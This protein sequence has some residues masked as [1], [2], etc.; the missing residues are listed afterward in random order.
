MHVQYNNTGNPV[1]TS[2]LS[3]HY[4]KKQIVVQLIISTALAIKTSKQCLFNN[5]AVHKNNIFLFL[6]RGVTF[7]G[8][9]LSDA[10]GH[11]LLT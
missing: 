2:R 1:S 8:R 6:L 7:K 9:T 10:R 3:L 5:Y 4:L 11:R